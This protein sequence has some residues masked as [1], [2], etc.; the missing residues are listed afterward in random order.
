MGQVRW[1]VDHLW[2]AFKHE[3]QLGKYLTVDEMMIGYKGTYYPATQ[4]LPNKPKKWGVKV[5]CLTDSKS[6]YIY[7]FEIYCGKSNDVVAAD[8]NAPRVEASMATKV[9]LDL[10]SGLG[11]KEHIVVMDNYFQV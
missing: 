5:W 10:L 2:G 11:R 4:H 8:A 7:D 9:V 1:L 3:W 6:K